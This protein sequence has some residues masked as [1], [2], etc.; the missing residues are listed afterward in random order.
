[1]GGVGVGAGYLGRPELTAEKFVPDPFASEPGSRLYVTGDLART[2][3][4]GDLDFLGRVD[5]QV[6]VRGFRIELGEVE[7]ALAPGRGA[8]ARA[9][10]VRAARLV[11]SVEPGGLPAA[12]LRPS[13][14]ARLPEPL[15]PGSFVLLDRLPLSANGKIDRRALAQI[16]PGSEGPEAAYEAPRTPAEEIVSGIWAE[17][18]GRERVGATDSFFDLGGHSLLATRVASRLRS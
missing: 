6:K 8:G 15:V 1:V 2:L 18:L 9:V 10:P 11:A 7:A 3:P 13:P 5:H 17:V 12:D 14:A 4:A 16:A